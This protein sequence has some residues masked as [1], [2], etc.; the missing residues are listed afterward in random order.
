MEKLEREQF[1][2]AKDALAF[3]SEV[4][5]AEIDE[6]DRDAIGESLRWYEAAK[7]ALWVA[8][9]KENKE[10]KKNGERTKVDI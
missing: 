8:Y 2:S 4:E 5:L 3:A 1:I 9:E 10:E 6:H 7:K